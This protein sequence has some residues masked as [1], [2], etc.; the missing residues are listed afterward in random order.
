MLLELPETATGGA[1]AR[2][3]KRAREDDE[4]MVVKEE[5]FEGYEGGA[6]ARRGLDVTRVRQVLMQR[7]AAPPRGRCLALQL[8]KVRRRRGSRPMQ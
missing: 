6:A 7:H 1:A 2:G 4:T 8:R 3:K 5:G